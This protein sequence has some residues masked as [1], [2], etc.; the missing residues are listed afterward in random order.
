[1][2]LVRITK[3][4]PLGGFRLRLTLTNGSTIE[5]DVGSLLVGPVFDSIRRDPVLFSQVEVKHGTVV[6]PG[7]VDLCPDVIIWQ[8]PPPTPSSPPPG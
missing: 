2:S 3:A 8:G 5:R 7:E 4:E 6:W 1:M